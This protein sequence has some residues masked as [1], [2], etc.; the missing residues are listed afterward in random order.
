MLVWFG[1]LGF[2]LITVV[3]CYKFIYKK[4][5]TTSKSGFWLFRSLI[6]YYIF[7]I[8][9]KLHFV[10]K[11]NEMDDFLQETNE[12]RCTLFLNSLWGIACL[13]I[14][15]S[16]TV[17]MTGYFKFSGISAI[18]FLAA[19]SLFFD[20]LKRSRIELM[21]LINEGHIFLTRFQQK[22]KGIFNKR[23]KAKTDEVKGRI[24]IGRQSI[25][26]AVFVLLIVICGDIVLA[27]ILRDMLTEGIFGTFS[28]KESIYASPVFIILSVLP[29][30]F[31]IILRLVDKEVREAIRQRFS[32]SKYIKNKA[33][34]E[35]WISEELN[36]L[37]DDFL[38]M[39]S[40]LNIKEVKIALYDSEEKQVF[41]VVKEGQVP[42]IIIGEQFFNKVKQI[43]QYEY[44]EI[45]ELLTAHELAH[46]HYRDAK[47]VKKI[48]VAALLVHGAMFALLVVGVMR[49]IAVCIVIA[50]TYI[51][52]QSIVSKILLDER[53]WNQVKEFRADAVGLEISNTSA[54]VLE[55]ALKCIS[56]GEDDSIVKKEKKENPV[57][58]FYKKSVEQQIHPSAERRIYEAK[59]RQ[60]WRKREYF[61]YL[62]LVGC[63]VFSGKGWKI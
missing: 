46:I 49:G 35:V 28:F 19:A 62:W 63:S 41:S 48:Y 53:Y 52:L 50:L 8:K 54:E 29:C 56:D 22:K 18:I 2:E 43:Y 16:I 38:Q 7:I 5:C 33:E 37:M 57:Y 39:C 11:S 6:S 15:P 23:E 40:V 58:T 51:I 24:R 20:M 27:L 26:E 36:D 31:F 21:K 13:I 34:V 25:V 59:R 3:V 47:P 14:L 4:K 44:L 45:I 1:F 61:R 42:V 12:F 17:F 32:Y 30:V 55:K 10:S 9:D 60:T